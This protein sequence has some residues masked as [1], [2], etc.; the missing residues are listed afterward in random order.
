MN[1]RDY[2]TF[3]FVSF[4]KC[5]LRLLKKIVYLM[6]ALQF[7]AAFVLI[8]IPLVLYRTSNTIK[9]KNVILSIDIDNVIL[10]SRNVTTNSD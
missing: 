1:A 7:N 10:F 8:S 9:L 5:T 2:K 3:I 4:K 6:P